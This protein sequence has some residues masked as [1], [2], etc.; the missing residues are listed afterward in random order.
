MEQPVWS[1][2]RAPSFLLTATLPALAFL[3][4][5]CATPSDVAT[6][7]VPLE[8][9]GMAGAVSGR[10]LA[11]PTG[12]TTGNAGVSPRQQTYLDGLTS[13]GVRRST[14][15]AALSIGSYICQG[16][17]AGQT[18]QAV[19]DFVFPMVRGDLEHLGGHVGGHVTDSGQ[20]LSARDATTRYLRIATERLC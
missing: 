14:D 6:S 11:A 5:G 12:A 16:R 20:K 9:P 10:A 15:L 1:P 2:E 7:M 18:D 19:W 3:I 8:E 4:G 17:A 13:A